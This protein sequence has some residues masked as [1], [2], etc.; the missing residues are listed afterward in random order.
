LNLNTSISPPG[1]AVETSFFSSGKEFGKSLFYPLR[2]SVKIC[3][4][5]I[6]GVI[7]AQFAVLIAEYMLVRMVENTHFQSSGLRH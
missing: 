6:A 4:E 2:I 5:K 1:N 7:K 3:N